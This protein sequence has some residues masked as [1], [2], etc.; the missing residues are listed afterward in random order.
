MKQHIFILISSIVVAAF[1]WCVF[2]FGLPLDGDEVGVG[3]L[4]ATGQAYTYPNQ[5]WPA[6]GGII[7][8]ADIK[9]CINYSPEYSVKDVLVSLRYSGMHPPFYYLLLHYFIQFFSNDSFVLRMISIFLSLICLYMIYLI[10]SAVHNRNT[11]LLATVFFAVAGYGL[12]GCTMVR[13][14]PL[15]MFISLVS[16]LQVIKLARKG[17]ITFKSISVYSYMLTA[18]LGLYTMYQ[19]CFVLVF[20]LLFL[21]ILYFRDRKAILT[22]FVASAIM[23]LFYLPWLPALLDQ[24]HTVNH[25]D[26]YFHR[27]VPL[28]AMIKHIT[29]VSI[30]E[31]LPLSSKIVQR[32]I[33]IVFIIVT[34]LLVC[35]GLFRLWFGGS[36]RIARSFGLAF[37]GYIT[38]YYLTEKAFHMNTLCVRKFLFFIMPMLF[39]LLALGISQVT[40]GYGARKILIVVL[41][42]LT[43]S[44]SLSA[45]CFSPR[46]KSYLEEFIPRIN[47][48]CREGSK[49]LL[50]TNSFQRRSLLPLVHE[51][52]ESLDVQIIFPQS[53]LVK[54]NA[55]NHIEY[56]NSIF[57]VNVFVPYEQSAYLSLHDIELI[58]TCLQK[59]GFRRKSTFQSGRQV[60]VHEL[61]IYENEGGV[62]NVE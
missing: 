7:P 21:A 44:N 17:G 52:G 40:T 38:I 11:G 24:L 49:N 34:G 14:Y 26:F 54:I 46:H 45:L 29:W 18:L 16:T 30:G 41:L 32:A 19:F 31:Y 35:L 23:I 1:L 39:I 57:I 43:L 47:E 50:I 13:P 25:G 5:F 27:V 8:I 22:I 60:N 28:S 53:S 2:A 58:S 55:V 6:S 12:I 20:Q 59:H 9:K 61:L 42:T 4:Q 37:V 36:G 62:R 10:G 15:A 51:L 48:Q 33:S 3:V 56:Y